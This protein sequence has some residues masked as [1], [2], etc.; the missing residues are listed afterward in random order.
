M[1]NVTAVRHIK[2]NTEYIAGFPR[3][4]HHF[5]LDYTGATLPEVC[6]WLHVNATGKWQAYPDTVPIRCGT[7]S[8]VKYHVIIH[9]DRDA[10]LFKLSW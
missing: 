5:Y 6:H 2:P 9:N 3:P 7:S 8:E 1:G 10:L 4:E